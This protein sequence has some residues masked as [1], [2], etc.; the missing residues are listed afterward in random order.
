MDD[1]ISRRDV[2]DVLETGEEFLRRVLDEVDVVGAERE[3]YE[4]GL[5]LIE[6]YISDMKELPS[7]QPGE[8]IRAMCGECDA[9]NQYKNYLHPGWI[10][11]DSGKFPKESGTYTVTA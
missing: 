2:I 1:L 6:S 9:W 3:K 5:G 7:A 11:W 8:D 10:P 4:W